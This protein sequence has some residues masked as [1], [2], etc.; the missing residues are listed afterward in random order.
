MEIKKVETYG[1]FGRV[2]DVTKKVTDQLLQAEYTETM[3]V[4]TNDLI[5]VIKTVEGCDRIVG[6]L[7]DKLNDSYA[8]AGVLA[9][10]LVVTSGYILYD[11]VLR[12]TKLVKNIK[13]KFSKKEVEA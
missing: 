11:K 6:G 1:D 4:K 8:V 7:K 2:V 12:K 5:D 9:A 3:E 10:G 13:N